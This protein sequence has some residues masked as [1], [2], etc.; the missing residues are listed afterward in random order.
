M[1]VKEKA[2]E[3]CSVNGLPADLEKALCLLLKEQDRDTRHACAEAIVAIMPEHL[4]I[5]EDK[6]WID[7][8]RAHSVCMNV[9]IC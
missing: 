3:F 4:D 7:Q 5:S 1:T 2:R 6:C 8:D 9:N